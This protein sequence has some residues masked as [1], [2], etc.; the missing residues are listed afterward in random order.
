[1]A[2]GTGLPRPVPK[3]R[4]RRRFGR[5]NLASRTQFV[6]RHPA[7]NQI[8]AVR[9]LFACY[10]CGFRLR[11]PLR[12]E[13]EERCPAVEHALSIAQ[14]PGLD[15]RARLCFIEEAVDV[16]L[17]LRLK[18]PE[19]RGPDPGSHSFVT[20]SASR[21]LKLLQLSR[22]RPSFAAIS[23]CPAPLRSAFCKRGTFEYQA[24]LSA[25]LNASFRR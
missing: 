19:L 25:D 1:M 6:K 11:L 22:K 18:P 13:A 12:K 8:G 17:K 15:F 21:S 14:E 23:A 2:A 4:T 20:I 7:A 3:R 16:E 9:R 24:S 10:L 5:E